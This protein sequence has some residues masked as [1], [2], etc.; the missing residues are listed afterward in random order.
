MHDPFA[1]GGVVAADECLWG[2]MNM[3]IYQM[4]NPSDA[5]HAR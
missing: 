1:L 3:R 5:M 4:L 2:G